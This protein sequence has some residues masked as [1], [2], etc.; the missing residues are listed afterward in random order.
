MCCANVYNNLAH[1]PQAGTNTRSQPEF[2]PTR[3]QAAR[4]YTRR[5]QQ[6][7]QDDSPHHASRNERPQHFQKC[8]WFYKAHLLRNSSIWTIQVK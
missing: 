5:D 7:I 1:D 8:K 4:T 3:K 6:Q 2:A